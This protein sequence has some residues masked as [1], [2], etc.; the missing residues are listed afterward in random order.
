MLHGRVTI[1]LHNEK[2]HRDERVVRDNMITNWLHDYMFNQHPFAQPQMCR[3]FSSNNWFNGLMMF[4]KPLNSDPDDYV[5]PIPS[6]A[7]M[8]AHGTTE[9]YL[10]TDLT[11]GSFN[12]GLSSNSNG[13]VT[14]V[15]DFTQEQGNGVIASV[16]LCRDWYAKVGSGVTYAL[17]ANTTARQSGMIYGAY[18]SVGSGDSK[19]DHAFWPL[20]VDGPN[21]RLYHFT[22][23]TT[24]AMTYEVRAAL[25]NEINPARYGWSSANSSGSSPGSLSYTSFPLI[26]THTINL[27]SVLGSYNVNSVLMYTGDP[28]YVWMLS[29]GESA[30]ANGTTR[31]LVKFKWSDGTYTTQSI[32]NNTGV[33]LQGTTYTNSIA[34][35]FAVYNGYFYMK[36]NATNSGKIGFIE[37]ADQT[38]AGTLKMPDGVTDFTTSRY[39]HLF[40]RWGNWLMITT[41]DM[42]PGSADNGINNFIVD[43]TNTYRIGYTYYGTSQYGG[44]GG[45]TLPSVTYKTVAAYQGFG[46]YNCAVGLME[47]PCLTTKT[48]LDAAVTK[49]ADLTMR[50]TYVITDQAE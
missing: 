13:V 47:V 16:G 41:A 44:S 11:R 9:T 49:T 45:I 12:S 4:D 37:L 21:S 48:N 15:W 33:S 1:D 50:V 19:P 10:G 18:C 26:E 43:G 40:P 32:T 35:N 36:N 42:C 22:G 34:N 3:G 14:K 31:T 38:N 24:S 8:T 2:T 6:V 29:G 39:Q 20:F 46:Y 30:W 17:E 27:S 7:R 5:F 25:I 23:G 28:G